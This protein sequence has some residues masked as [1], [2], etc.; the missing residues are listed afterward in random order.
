MYSVVLVE[1]FFLLYFEQ[2]SLFPC[3]SMTF[4]LP[5][6]TVPFLCISRCA[7][8]S[9]WCF[10]HGFHSSTLL[11][12]CLS[13]SSARVESNPKPFVVSP[14]LLVAAQLVYRAPHK[15]PKR[16][17]VGTFVHFRVW[18]EKNMAGRTVWFENCWFS[19]DVTMIQNLKLP[20]LLRF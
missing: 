16:S 15:G 10:P 6:L 13:V 17:T 14:T 2:D 18:S 1:T 3:R 20:F 4:S 5:T 12:M 9:F 8:V 7:G 19:C 11:A